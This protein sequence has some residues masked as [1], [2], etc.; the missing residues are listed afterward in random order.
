MSEQDICHV[1]PVEKAIDETALESA[2]AAYLSVSGMG[3]PRCAIRVRNGLLS[4]E[5]VLLAEV[6]LEQG[7][8]AAAFDA[9]KVTPENL[10]AAVAAAG[11][12]GHHNYQA[13]FIKQ[14]PAA[15]A[16]QL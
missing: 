1:E 6:H 7:V 5:G 13:V 2:Q 12:D 8:A 4:L 10:V 9:T 11:N 3:C 15:Q 16:V 14:V